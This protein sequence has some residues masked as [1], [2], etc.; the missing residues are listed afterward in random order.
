MFIDFNW[1]KKQGK[2]KGYPTW[3]NPNQV[4]AFLDE[5]S[6]PPAASPS[7]VNAKALGMCFLLEVWVFYIDE[8]QHLITIVMNRIAGFKALK[9]V[10]S[11]ITMLYSFDCLH[12]YRLCS[13][14]YVCLQCA[15]EIVLC[16]YCACDSHGK[17]TIKW[18]G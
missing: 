1:K 13:I 10:Q 15:S 5:N 2:I 8:L 14:L 4:E 6:P 7:I 18:F 12:I 16:L 9:V 11:W 17:T 3:S